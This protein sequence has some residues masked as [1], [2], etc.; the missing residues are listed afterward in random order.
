MWRGMRIAIGTSVVLSLIAT[1]AP[2]QEIKVFVLTP[3]EV[4]L[5]GV[6]K[7]AVLDLQGTNGDVLSNALIELLM[8]G[9]RGLHAL[10]T[11]PLGLGT[12]EGKTLQEGARTNV[13]ELVERSR[14]QD[15][16]REQRLGQ[17][18]LVDDSQ[19]AQV[20]KLLGVD[21]V[22]AGTLTYGSADKNWRGT[23]TVRRDGQNIEVAVN[24]VTREV[25]A[26]ARIRVTHAE[27]GRILGTTEKGAAKKDDE[28]EPSLGDLASPGDLLGPVLGEIA[29]AL[30]DYIAPRFEL[31]EFDLKK[32]NGKDVEKLAKRAGDAAKELRVDEAFAMYK[33]LHDKDRYSPELAY[34]VGVLHEVVGNASQA[35]EYYGMACQL[36]DDKDCRKAAE[37][38]TRA[39]SFQESLSALGVQIAQHEFRVTEEALASATARSLEIRGKREDR[40]NVLAEP[41]DGSEVVAAVPGGVTFPILAEEG[42]WYRIKLLGGKEGYVHRDK[43]KVKD[44]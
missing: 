43:V 2:G 17:A 28:C 7:L 16:L 23:R 35:V 40:V 3:P 18:G 6:K 32:I 22:L 10:R 14:L 41:R 26:V 8:Q 34:N 31:Q 1:P 12:R 39:A 25:K 15:V 42:E 27:T 29:S 30:A 11:G 4:V 36:K 20:G 38:A 9:A 24:C 21:A 5:A 19:A 13:F 44:R 33:S 37:R